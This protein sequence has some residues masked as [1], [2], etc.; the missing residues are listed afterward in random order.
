MSEHHTRWLTKL[1]A[2]THDPA[3]K[4]L[5]LL[6]DSAGHEGGTV[7]ELRQTFFPQG[8]PKAVQEAIK[9]ADHWASAAD[10]P[11]FGGGGRDSWAQVRFDQNPILIHPLSGEEY[12]LGNLGDISPAHIKALSS[13]HFRSLIVKTADGDIDARRTA[14][15][16]W[17]FG[18]ELKGSELAH[19]WQLLPAD[20]RIPDHSIWSHL[21]LS[22]AFATAFA[23]D[24]QG[25]A[26]LLSM[27][28][29]PVQDFIAAARTTS[30]LWAGSHLLSRIAWEGLR[31]ICGQLG[32]DA[33]VFP[34]LRGVPQVDLWLRDDIGL[35]AGHFADLEWVDRKTDAN[36]LFLPALPNKFVAIVPAGQAAA[37]AE[38]VTQAVRD[39]VR[40]TAQSMLAE[41]LDKAKLA[42]TPDLP[43]HAQLSAQL[44]G[45]PEVHWAA[46]PFSL[47]AQD[48]D[49]KALAQQESL[50]A[51]SRPFLGNVELPGFLGSPV[52]QI[53]SKE[54]SIAGARFFTPNP[55]VLYPAIYDLLDRVAAAAKSVR[56]FAQTRHEGYRCDLSGEAE[57]L[58]TDRA[59]LAWGKQGRKDAPTLWNEAA[60]E[61]RG[62]LRQGEHLGA[63]GMLKRLWPRQF[64]REIRNVIGEDLNRYVVSTH[65]MALATSLERWLDAGG[66][67]TPEAAKLLAEIRPRTQPVALPRQLAETLYQHPETTRE[68]ARRLPA[69][70][71]ADDLDSNDN[72]VDDNREQ[73]RQQVARLLDQKPEAYY[74]FILMDGDKMG[75]WL[76]GTEAGYTLPFEQTWHPQIR[77]KA[78]G[79]FPALDDYLQAPRPVSPARH[80]A[81]SGALNSFS[82]H[83][84]RHIV[85]DRCKGKLIYAGGDDVLAMVSVDDL[86][87]C[88]FLLR[89]GYAGIWP[90]Q[91]GLEELLATVNTPKAAQSKPAQFKR[92]HALY[93]DQLL[94]L[95]GEK[96]TASAGA[97]VAHHQTPLGRV[98][99]E[100]RSTEKKAK[101]EGGRDAISI[102]LLKRSGG[103]VHL[104]LPWLQPSSTWPQALQDSLTDTPVALLIKLQD[105]FA[106]N[107]S[108][109]AAY[110]TQGWLT[111]LPSAAQIGMDTLQELLARNL[112]YQ[113]TRQGGKTAGP[114]GSTLAATACCIARQR[115]QEPAPLVRDLLAVAEFLARK[116]RTGESS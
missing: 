99:R 16:F 19:L 111:D 78:K 10:R 33:L 48:K 110:I 77:T 73:R 64:V 80:M 52:W 36:P 6:R 17:R 7:R 4:A 13:D 35:A 31:V 75:A 104:T 107:T 51:A 29:G 27:S 82:L 92:G 25:E 20:T 61:L 59:Q 34:Q 28:F 54:I 8:V 79:K 15:A 89:L 85:E 23:T 45:F 58:T 74:A 32:P 26:A 88:L 115:Q 83:I 93:N 113:L 63:L 42:N 98:L 81:I 101:N 60:K 65:T 71:D 105:L 76:S 55:G 90:E 70:L 22:S 39:W 1:A 62:L 30:D 53:L 84:A 38:Q 100:L 106:G 14:L 72:K 114:L 69:W 96:A 9:Q 24:P 40:N 86:L 18:P 49:G 50:A 2:W 57:W 47:I 116:G 103:A 67:N 109:R 95:M 112:A 102:N 68:L 91:A 12:S 108:R 43:C 97:V 94:R 44:A 87:R 21:D 56:P 5:V 46:V 41:L 3:E 11:Q 66:A 37:L